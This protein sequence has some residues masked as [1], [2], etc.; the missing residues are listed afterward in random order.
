MARYDFV[1][2]GS[3]P[4]DRLAMI[5][6][7]LLGAAALSVSAA[8]VAAPFADLAAIDREVES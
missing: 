5:L 2:L 8:A 1:V 6:R 3:G 7:S 4:A